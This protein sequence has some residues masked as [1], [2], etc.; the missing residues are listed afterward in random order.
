MTWQALGVVE[1]LWMWG[2][3]V[4]ASL[5]T[6]RPWGATWGQSWHQ[7]LSLDGCQAD[8]IKI[9]QKNKTKIC[10]DVYFKKWVQKYFRLT[11]AIAPL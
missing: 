2:P 7:H 5:R 1:D 8:K 10:D 9:K 3:V 11:L 4:E 6:L